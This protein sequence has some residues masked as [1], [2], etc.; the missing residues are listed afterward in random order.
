[1]PHK[2]GRPRHY[3]DR[4]IKRPGRGFSHGQGSLDRLILLGIVV[5][6]FAVIMLV[7]FS[8]PHER[9]DGKVQAYYAGNGRSGV[10]EVFDF[11]GVL[12]FGMNSGS[13][14]PEIKPAVIPGDV[15]QSK[16]PDVVPATGTDKEPVIRACSNDCSS[17]GL[18][19]CSGSGY[20]VCGNFDEDDCLEWGSWTGCPDGRACANGNCEVSR[21]V[22]SSEGLVSYWRFDDLSDS[23]GS[24]DLVMSGNVVAGSSPDC[25]FGG[26]LALDSSSGQ[27]EARGL[28][29]S[30]GLSDLSIALRVKFG[31]GGDTATRA[32]VAGWADAQGQGV[33]F[34]RYGASQ[35]V[36]F[37][38]GADGSLTDCWS[39]AL[40]DGKWHRL[41]G[42]A[43]EQH[44]TLFVDGFPL[45]YKAR[46]GAF[47]SGASFKAGG[48]V[49]PSGS[50]LVDELMVFDRSF[51]QFVHPQA[52]YTLLGALPSNA[53]GMRGPVIGAGGAVPGVYL[54]DGKI[55]FFSSMDAYNYYSLCSYAVSGSSAR[56][57]AVEYGD[58]YN[59]FFVDGGLVC[60]WPANRGLA[61]ARP[62][63]DGY[64][65][66]GAAATTRLQAG[67]FLSTAGLDGLP[68]HRKRLITAGWLSPD[69]KSLKEDLG[70]YDESGF[71]G[72]A[73]DDEVFFNEPGR[74]WPLNIFQKTALSTGRR[75]R[76]GQFDA[77][78]GEVGQAL[79]KAKNLKHNY[80]VLYLGWT[81]SSVLGNHLSPVLDA[82]GI[83]VFDANGLKLHNLTA[84]EQ[85]QIIAGNARVAAGLAKKAGLEGIIIDTEQNYSVNTQD[86]GYIAYKGSPLTLS[87]EQSVPVNPAPF[88]EYEAAARQRGQQLASAMA[89]E[90]PDMTVLFHFAYSLYSDKDRKETGG[91]DQKSYL[92]RYTLLPA[93][94]DGMLEGAPGIRFIDGDEWTYTI[95]RRGQLLDRKKH[96]LENA[97]EKSA[98]NTPGNRQIE[99]GQELWAT[100]LEQTPDDAAWVD[101]NF[102]PEDEI[103]LAKQFGYGIRDALR[104]SEGMVLIWHAQRPPWPV[105]RTARNGQRYRAQGV[106]PDSFRQAIKDARKNVEGNTNPVMPV[107]G[108]VSAGTG[109]KVSITLPEASD[110][111]GDSLITWVDGLPE[112]ASYEPLSRTI[113]WPNPRAGIYSLSYGASDGFLE[114]AAQFSLVIYG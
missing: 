108:F 29:D 54:F 1:M 61:V 97:L 52:G 96:F 36:F 37:A 39:S 70:V 42:E 98:T 91:I 73:I 40:N 112:G 109:E 81:H 75:Y 23:F 10:R 16:K 15:N 114:A 8:R 41:A 80:M 66:E 87:Y 30:G 51:T 9:A 45:C 71:D 27:A 94:I 106:M 67:T 101:V 62:P 99:Y 13:G 26:C 92:E 22:F 48:P 111:D 85:W 25:A 89:E 38:N 17:A 113:E 57:F 58:R 104:A 11:L 84:D 20:N 43:S 93:F 82:D 33:G 4:A 12:K 5:L 110:A 65:N 59:T 19:Q 69:L 18:R 2:T 105:Y 76:E 31:A 79:G 47:L 78:A 14:G 74:P 64:A 6:V 24:N 63:D 21:G 56:S 95:R 44:I 102:I 35:L 107:V 28:P 7:A 34:Y 72:I 55:Y 83:P 49:S 90:Y 68:V 3:S 86:P 32:W 53:L 77:V 46:S 103:E 50:V 100:V 88:A 60:A